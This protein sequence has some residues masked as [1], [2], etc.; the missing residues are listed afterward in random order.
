MGSRVFRVTQLKVVQ[1]TMGFCEVAAIKSSLRIKRFRWGAKREE[2]R[3]V[4]DLSKLGVSFFVF[5]NLYERRDVY[6]V[7]GAVFF[8][9]SSLATL[10]TLAKIW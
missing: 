10:I 7:R 5:Q 6:K 4:T 1:L 9:P 2:E 3:N 8:T